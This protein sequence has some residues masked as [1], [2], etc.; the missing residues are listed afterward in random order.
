MNI[1]EI[2]VKEAAE[3]LHKGEQFV[4]Q[5]IING[6][7]PGAYAK[8]G[9]RTN[10]FIPKKAFYDFAERFVRKEKEPLP[11]TMTQD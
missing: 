11:Q 5:A 10:F 8:V 6:S 3:A 1:E 7:L 4:R 2:S 9:K